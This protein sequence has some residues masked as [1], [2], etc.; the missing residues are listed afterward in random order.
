MLDIKKQTILLHVLVYITLSI[1]C[2]LKE[3]GHL[4]EMS[5]MN[6]RAVTRVQ[7]DRRTQTTPDRTLASRSG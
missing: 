3:S 6:S 7:C 4:I 5:G 1:C 2:K